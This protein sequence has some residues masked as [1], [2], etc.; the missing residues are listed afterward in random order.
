VRLGVQTQAVCDRVVQQKV[1]TMT[2]AELALVALMKTQVGNGLNL[3]WSVPFVAAAL[4]VAYAAFPGAK[5]KA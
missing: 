5:A 4:A 3:M 1:Y 2:I